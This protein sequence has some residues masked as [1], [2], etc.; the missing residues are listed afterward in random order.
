MNKILSERTVSSYPISIGTSMALETF[1]MGSNPPYDPERQVTH[2]SILK[3]QEMWIN[4]FTL[5]RNLVGAVK[6]EDRDRLK[7]DDIA[8]A[9][10]EE[11]DVID[12]ALMTLSGGKTKP[13]YYTCSYTGIKNAFAYAD[14]RS[15][16]TEKQ[17]AYTELAEKSI[18]AFYKKYK[19]LRV[20]RHFTLLISPNTKT[21]AI[22]LTHYA[23]D[24]LSWKQFK[25]LALLES[26]TGHIKPR[27]E[28]YTKYTNGKEQCAR[29]PWDRRM[30]QVFGDSNTF[31]PMKKAVRDAVL[32]VAEE[33]KWT[34]A[35]TTD[36]IDLGLGLMKDKYAAAI[37]AKMK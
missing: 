29:I 30:L 8:D 14:L 3:Y 31:A 22:I 12:A 17:K 15:D 1:G 16:T 26:H 2:A 33:Y 32:A 11:L 9:L 21:D 4:L 19:G 25:S 13:V 10:A 34:Q 28:W 37:L 35:T 24:L 5:F 18:N 6:T 27:T 20:H 23:I 7:P 36:R